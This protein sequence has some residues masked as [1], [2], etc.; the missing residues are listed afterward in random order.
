MQ[1]KS[2]YRVNME[3]K[4]L[5]LIGIVMFTVVSTILLQKIF[6]HMQFEP[7]KTG[8]GVDIKN[9]FEKDQP[10]SISESSVPPEFRI[11]LQVHLGT[12]N[13]Y[14]SDTDSRE[15]EDLFEKRIG[16]FLEVIRDPDSEDFVSSSVHE[17]LLSE[18]G[19]LD[20]LRTV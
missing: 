6:T 16:E 14:S 19:G 9:Y 11:V 2:I 18:L 7:S 3:L 13:G 5:T 10:L 8:S 17:L 12:D 15:W 4:T 20:V 1:N